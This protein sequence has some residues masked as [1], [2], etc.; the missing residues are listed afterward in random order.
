LVSI[1]GIFLS[2]RSLTS[3]SKEFFIM[4]LLSLKKAGIIALASLLGVGGAGVIASAANAATVGAAVVSF[5]AEDIYYSA[6]S[7]DGAIIAYASYDSD[8]VILFDTATGTT[9]VVSDPDTDINGPGAVVFTP[10]G[11]TIYVTNYNSGTLGSVIE[12]DVATAAV[13]DTISPSAPLFF[14]GPWTLAISPDGNYLYIGDAVLDDFMTYDIVNDAWNTESTVG[15]QVATFVSLDGNTAYVFDYYGQIDVF[16]VTDPM[17][18]ALS[19]SWTNLSGEF[20]GACVDSGVTTVYV[21]D[22]NSSSLYAVSLTDGSIVVE[23]DAT[24]PN[25]ESQ[26]SCAVS[27]DDSSV[28]VTDYDFGDQTA[29]GDPV[30]QGGLVTEYNASTLA[31]VK[32]YDFSGVAFT[33]M[34][35]FYN[36]CDAYVAGYYGNAQQL[37]LDS[38]DCATLPDTGASQTLVITLASVGGALLVLG[39]IAMALARRRQKA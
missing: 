16:D 12:I 30:V 27:P 18:P 26:Y 33:Q 15:D 21:P 3:I 25:S 5:D 9:Q 38:G 1:Q 20:Y 23:N 13:V 19:D 29:P 6:T 7:A 36:S 31:Q 11:A 32:Q 35:N 37:T 34:M 14:G 2:Q 17:N 8:E 4:K 28:F 10:D 22:N 24:N 39:V